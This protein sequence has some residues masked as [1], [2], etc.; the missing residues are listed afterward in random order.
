MEVGEVCCDHLTSSDYATNQM[1]HLKRR[2]RFL[3]SSRWHGGKSGAS[4]ITQKGV[5]LSVIP[6]GSNYMLRMNGTLGRLK[7]GSVMEAKMKAFDLIDSGVAQAYLLKV[8]LR[9]DSRHRWKEEGV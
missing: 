3:F 7:F 2:T 5:V 6:D 1:R 9:S 4:S 8:K